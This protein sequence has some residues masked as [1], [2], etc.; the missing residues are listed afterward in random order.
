MTLG[1]AYFYLFAGTLTALAVLIGLVLVSASR[2]KTVTDRILCVNMVGT[3]VI[4]SLAILSWLLSESYLTDV[5]LIYAMISFIT[6]LMLAL[7]YIPRNPARGR[8]FV[9]ATKTEEGEAK[10]GGE[11]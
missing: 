2:K 9:E 7:T 11:V 3:M 8:F 10:T 4:C 1:R 5:A 6:V